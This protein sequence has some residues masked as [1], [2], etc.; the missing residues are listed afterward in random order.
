[1]FMLF[2]TAV[3]MWSRS[4]LVTVPFWSIRRSAKVRMS[5]LRLPIFP[6]RHDSSAGMTL[7]SMPRRWRHAWLAARYAPSESNVMDRYGQWKTKW[8]VPDLVRQARVPEIG[9]GGFWLRGSWSTCKRCRWS[10]SPRQS[11][12]GCR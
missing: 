7:C 8:S 2:S 11:R 12:G 4:C 9:P 10:G 5:A 3:R 6:R 1:M